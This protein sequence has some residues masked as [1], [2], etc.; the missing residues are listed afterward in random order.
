M[1]AKVRV[2]FRNLDETANERVELARHL[3]KAGTCFLHETSLNA[4]LVEKE[5]TSKYTEKRFHLIVLFTQGETI[6]CKNSLS[7]YT[8]GSTTQIL[9]ILGTRNHISNVST[10]YNLCK[11]P[12]RDL[13]SPHARND[14]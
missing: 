4:A 13:P 9:E 10:E 14:F 2:L 5:T 1:G 7:C 3:N 8:Y 11:I 6:H 12:T